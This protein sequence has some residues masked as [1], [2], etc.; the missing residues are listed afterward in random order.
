MNTAT[1]LEQL[2][3]SYRVYYN[4]N[5]DQAEPPFSAQADFSLHDEQYFLVKSA[6]ISEAD[7]KEHV[8]FA[9]AEHL[10]EETFK[11]LDTAAWSKGIARVKPHG[12]H[13]N[14][15][16]TLVIVADVID[17]AVKKLIP[18]MKR[19]KSYRFGLHGWSHYRLAAIELSTGKAVCNRQGRDLQK[20]VCNIK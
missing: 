12:S 4:V 10:D 8:Y 13:K 6:R 19:Y 1:A 3:R 17:E 11:K 18:K 20:L 15:D 9:E 5:S 16:I 7:S 14:T 2:L